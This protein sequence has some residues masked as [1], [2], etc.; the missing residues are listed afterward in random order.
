MACRNSCGINEAFY[1]WWPTPIVRVVRWIEEA[2]PTA[3][4][5]TLDSR[6][7]LSWLRSPPDIGNS[8][9]TGLTCLACTLAASHRGCSQS[10]TRLPFRAGA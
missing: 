2:R 9:L 6:R 4:S 8:G 10:S 7:E 5:F 3:E 1:L